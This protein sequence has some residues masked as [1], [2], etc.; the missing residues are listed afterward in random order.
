MISV[1]AAMAQKGQLLPPALK[2]YGG[3]PVAAAFHFAELIKARSLLEAIA[4]K[5]GKGPGE[6]LHPIWL[7][8]NGT[9][10]ISW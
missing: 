8:G 6:A 3:D 1:L 9:C 2:F 4:A 7:P 10:G 5:A